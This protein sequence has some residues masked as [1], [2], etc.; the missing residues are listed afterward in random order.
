MLKDPEGG[1]SAQ[2][3]QECGI[4]HVS[5]PLAGTVGFGA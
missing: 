2:G 5:L 4:L 3:S 1:L